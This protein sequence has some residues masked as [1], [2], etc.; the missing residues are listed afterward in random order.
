M[1]FSEHHVEDGP[2][3]ESVSY[4]QMFLTARLHDAEKAVEA[5]A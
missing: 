4:G 2:V 3:P 5:V 1:K